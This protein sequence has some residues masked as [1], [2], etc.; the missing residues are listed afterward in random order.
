MRKKMTE[1][2]KAWRKTMRERRK[3][4]IRKATHSEVVF[5]E[6]LKHLGVRYIAQKG[7]I[8]K[9]FSCIVDFYLPRPIGLCIEVDG[10]YHNTQERKTKDI[11]KDSYLKNQRG[12]RVLRLTNEQAEAITETEL[13]PWFGRK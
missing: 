2:E 3:E 5:E 13:R 4:L 9:G 10:G 7:F 1:K 6:K 12:F 8:A 11:L